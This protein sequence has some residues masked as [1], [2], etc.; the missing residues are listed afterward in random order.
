MSVK[1]QNLRADNPGRAQL[2][3]VKAEVTLGGRS[4]DA[5]EFQKGALNCNRDDDT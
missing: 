5:K 2:S 4:L 1:K 3:R